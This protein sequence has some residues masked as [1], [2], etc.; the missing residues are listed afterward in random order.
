MS[1]SGQRPLAPSQYYA[2]FTQRLVSALS[3]PTTE[4][5]LYEVDMRLRP[6]GQKGPV[7]TQ[8]SSFIHYQ[9]NEAWTWE[10][11]ALTRARVVSG[12]P[13]ITA[14]VE[15]AIRDALLKR[16]D[17]DKIAADVRDMRARIAK[18]KGT[19]DIWDLKQVRGGLVDLEFIAQHLQLVHAADNPSV[20]DQNT[21]GAYQKLQ[22]AGYLS[23]LHAETLISRRAADKQFRRSCGSASPSAST[24]PPRRQASR[25]FLRGRVVRRASPCSRRNYASASRPSPLSSPRSSPDS[26][27][28][29]QPS[30]DGTA[31]PHAF[32]GQRLQIRLS[33]PPSTP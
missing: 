9:A 27:R 25:S 26:C 33:A 8:L 20:L 10:H 28:F 32:S 11:L 6:S 4:G 21:V 2:R 23:E 1:S 7:A 30:R 19:D 31:D 22:A 18:E 17:R 3:V 13:E 12:P 16:R 14:R 29:L 15:A 5:T 24:Q